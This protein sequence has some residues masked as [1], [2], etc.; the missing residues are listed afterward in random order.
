M[1]D[2]MIAAGMHVSPRDQQ[3]NDWLRN[4]LSGP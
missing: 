2:R 4:K 3:S 1:F